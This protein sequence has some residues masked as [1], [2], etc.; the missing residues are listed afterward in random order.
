V[1]KF[2]QTLRN[3]WSID[4]LRSKIVV[5]LSLIFVYRIGTYIV[6]CRVSTRIN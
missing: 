4:D 2:L 6:Y 5:T 1:K 3:I